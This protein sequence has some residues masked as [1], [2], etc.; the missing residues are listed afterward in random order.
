MRSP[1]LL[2][3]ARQPIAGNAKTRLVPAYA[4]AQAAAIAD[5]LIRATVAQAV[6][7]WPGAIYLCGAPDADH[8]L[9]HE[10]ARHPKVHLRAQGPGDLGAKMYDALRFGIARH[11]A[12]AV[13]GCDVPHCPGAVLTR[14][15]TLL[16]RGWNPL[17]PAMDGGYYLIGLRRASAGLFNRMPWGGAGVLRATRVRARRL[18]IAFELLPVLRDIDTAADVRA[19]AEVYAP[20]REFL[21]RLPLP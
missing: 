20:L 6:A 5:F 10:L 18:G 16:A 4:A 8:P 9:F 14:A 2:V 19:V 12:A 15:Y 3:F 1:A 17:G 11:G 13:L 7:R 21:A